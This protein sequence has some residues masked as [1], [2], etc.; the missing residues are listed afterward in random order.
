M[1]NKDALF[2]YAGKQPVLGAGV[3]IAP[4]ARII[5][6]V[7]IADNVSIWFNA[8]IRGDINRIS[9]GQGS[10]IQ[11]CAAL[12]VNTTMSDDPGSGVLTIGE[13]VVVGHG[14]ILHGCTIGNRVLVGIK[15]VVLD[16]AVIGDGV[17]IA[18]GA[19]VTPRM[20]IPTGSMVAGVPARVVRTLRTEEVEGIGFAARRYQEYAKEMQKSV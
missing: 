14:A 12:H 18:A 3:F 10:N 8:V 17:I 5:G 9:I 7:I 20:V 6:D 13:E 16:G 19:V 11:D 4:G 1:E 2:G 15:S